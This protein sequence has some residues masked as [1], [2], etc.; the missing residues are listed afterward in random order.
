MTHAYEFAYD[1]GPNQ[2]DY[3]Q[4]LADL[5]ANEFPQ[6]ELSHR[7]QEFILAGLG[8]MGQKYDQR[9]YHDSRHP[10]EVLRRGFQWLE[11]FARYKNVALTQDDY[12]VLAIASA[13]HDNILVSDNPEKSPERLSADRTQGLMYFLK[14]NTDQ[15]DRVFNAIL[16]TEVEYNG[17]Q[18]LQTMAVKTEPDI[19]TA[20]LLMADI[21]NVIYKDDTVMLQDMTNVAAEELYKIDEGIV[22]LKDN[23]TPIERV[24]GIFDKQGI[25]RDQRFSDL[26]K[27]LERHLGEAAAKLFMSNYF[28]QLTVQRAAIDDLVERIET[29]RAHLVDEFLPIVTS[30]ETTSKQK[31]NALFEAARIILSLR[32]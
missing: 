3:R 32:S 14:Y 28:D 11:E 22:S 29:R 26:P 12:E 4:D 2:P 9:P 8:E 27:I 23:E 19:V 18:V 31:A 17:Q 5:L 7:T 20:A 13:Y 16:A 21:G 6:V 15:T 24:I 1:S 25:F 30:K 10:F